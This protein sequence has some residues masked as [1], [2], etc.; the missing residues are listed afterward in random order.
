MKVIVKNFK[1]SITINDIKEELKYNPV[2]KFEYGD[3]DNW[4]T[5]L[6]PDI[7]V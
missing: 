5:A 3:F 7:N 1:H 2:E 6:V 4:I